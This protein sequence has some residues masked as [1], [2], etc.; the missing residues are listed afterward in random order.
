MNDPVAAL[1]ADALQNMAVTEATVVE[2]VN[3]GGNDAD[4]WTKFLHNS[5]HF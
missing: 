2:C 4:F 3:A 5:A 1:V